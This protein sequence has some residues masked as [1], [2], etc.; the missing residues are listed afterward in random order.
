VRERLAQSDPRGSVHN[1]KATW[2][3]DRN[4]P[5]HFDVRGNFRKLAMRAHEKLRAWPG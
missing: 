5:M 2:S 4:D 3:G 1:V